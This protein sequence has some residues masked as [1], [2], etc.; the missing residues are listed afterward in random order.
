M[1]SKAVPTFIVTRKPL[2]LLHLVGLFRVPIGEM[3]LVPGAAKARGV[4]T[5]RT[6]EGSKRDVDYFVSLKC[7]RLKF[8]CCFRCAGVMKGGGRRR[9]GHMRGGGGLFIHRG[10]FG[11]PPPAI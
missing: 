5:G 11:S 4:E 3:L 7:C 8:S 10:G 6:H 2:P 1:L 9:G